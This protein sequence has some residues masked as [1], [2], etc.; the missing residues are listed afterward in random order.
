MITACLRVA[1]TE[2]L[3]MA[4]A[5]GDSL[6]PTLDLVVAL[7]ARNQSR[8]GLVER[9]PHIRIAG[10]RDELLKIDRGAGQPAPRCQSE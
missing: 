4:G 2:S 10:L 3:A 6:A 9:A 7:E 8:R 5:F 1:A